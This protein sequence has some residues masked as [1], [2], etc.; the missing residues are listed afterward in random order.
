MNGA[1]LSVEGLRVAYGQ[2]RDA[3]EVLHGLDLTVSAGE[4]VGLVG[5]SGSGKSVASLAVLG[6]LGS[7]G[8]VTGGRIVFEGEDLA[9]AGEAH[10]RELRGKR[11]SMIFQDPGTALNPA[12]T[13]GTQ[14]A[15]VIRAHRP[16][17][18]RALAGE[19]ED[20]LARV[21]FRDPR[22][23]ARAYPHELS[24]GMKQRALI[25][26]A[27]VCEP[28]L[29]IADEPT[30]ALDVTVQAQIV[31]LLRSLVRELNMG[32]VFITHNLDLMA[33][34]CSRAVVLRHGEI[35]EHGEVAQLFMQPAHAY[36]RQLIDCIPRLPRE[37][38]TG[39]GRNHAA[40]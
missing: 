20:I 21:G 25:A 22:R 26:A 28:S 11:L 36:T 14:I 24:G 2:G 5:E 40:I 15:D 19:I 18:G 30:T 6:L 35:V 1:L 31:A 7:G 29:L 12:F 38:M 16:V 10:L 3:L 39:E 13:I 17:R 23:A 4:A 32:L 33:E 9:Q 37:A 8:H 27:I 34:L